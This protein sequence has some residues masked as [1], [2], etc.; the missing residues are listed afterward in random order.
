MA[1]AAGGRGCV[2]VDLS[3]D[4]FLARAVEEP[5]AVAVRPL[6]ADK[7]PRTAWLHGI[8]GLWVAGLP[9]ETA[10]AAEG[11]NRTV[12]LPARVFTREQHLKEVAPGTADPVSRVRGT[13]RREKDLDRWAYYP[14]WRFRRR[15]PG[16]HDPSGERWLVL[17]EADGEGAQVVAD[18][19]SR[20]VDC[21]HVAPRQDG[22]DHSDADVLF[23]RPGDEDSVKSAVR[24]MGLDQ[25]PLDRVVHLWCTGPLSDGETLEGRLAVLGS[26]YDRG[27]YTLLY[28]VQEIG[29]AQGSRHVRLDIAARGMQPMSTDP[30]DTVP[31]RA[32][33]AGPGLVIPQDFPGHVGPHPRHH[34]APGG[35]LVHR[36]GEGTPRHLHRHHRGPDSRFALGEVLRT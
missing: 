8:A 12:E 24:A 14:S 34:R 4:G 3:P 32:L 26:E 15:G 7:D 22:A 16:S 30:E 5:A 10:P 9:C 29:L 36:T 23:V 20:G 21:V 33:L 25:R 19:R 27:F 28:A 17:A 35:R 6:R 13:V 11:A 31:D 18:L 1:E 2:V